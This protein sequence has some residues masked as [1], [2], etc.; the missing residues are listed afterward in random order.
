MK[1][2]FKNLPGYDNDAEISNE[3]QPD[4]FSEEPRSHAHY[5]RNRSLKNTNTS[6][7]SNKTEEK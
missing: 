5:A 3:L 6:Q 2:P 7:K 1:K 4:P